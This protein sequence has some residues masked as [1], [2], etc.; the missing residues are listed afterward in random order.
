MEE[1]P[2]YIRVHIYVY[3]FVYMCTVYVT[4]YE[5]TRKA[6]TSAIAG[7]RTSGHDRESEI[8]E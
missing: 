3:I 7:R 8:R 4:Y 6:H 1:W 5:D 2:S